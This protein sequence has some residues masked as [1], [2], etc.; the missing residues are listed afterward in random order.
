[1]RPSFSRFAVLTLATALGLAGCA[2]DTSPDDLDEEVEPGVDEQALGATALDLVPLDTD[3]PTGNLSAGVTRLLTDGTSTRALLG[4]ASPTVDYSRSWLVAYRPATKSATSRVLLTRAQ[5]SASG[6]TLSVWATI[7]EAGA[8]CAPYWPNELVVVRVPSRAKKPNAVRV[9]TTRATYAC[10]LVQ[11]GACTLGGPPC[12]P[13][14]PSCHGALDEEGGPK[15]PGVCTKYPTYSGT[16][17][18]C[19]SDAAC[20]QGGICAGLSTSPEGLCQAAW[21]RGT[22]STPSSGQLS[23]PLPQGG[24]WHR[25]AI[26]VTGQSTVPMDAWVQVFADNIDPARVEWRLSNSTGTTST[27]VR[28]KP[29]GA[30]V[31]V[32]VPGDESVNGEWILEVRDTGSGAPG[33][34]RGARLSVTSRW[35]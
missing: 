18:S 20:G 31:P 27:T 12:P 21:M 11:G 15:A 33:Y 23:A 16:S 6:K 2:A 32:G 34:L 25:L 35:D 19:R 17:G 14:T 29:F 10:G 7:T 9:Y 3:V 30:H 5:I 24:A 8:G 22:Y 26:R 13:A 4:A 28:G 1:M